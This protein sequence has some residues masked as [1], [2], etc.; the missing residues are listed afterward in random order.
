MPL[1]VKSR[2]YEMHFGILKDASRFYLVVP[3]RYLP[4]A[5]YSTTGTKLSG[6]VMKLEGVEEKD[7]FRT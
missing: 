4:D 3:S 1:Y 6:K 5:H 2:V 7:S